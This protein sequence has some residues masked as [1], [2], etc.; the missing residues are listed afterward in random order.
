MQ[1]CVTA[2]RRRVTDYPE[3]AS[4]SPMATPDPLPHVDSPGTFRRW[5][6]W[7]APLL[8]LSLLAASCGDDASDDGAAAETTDLVS[9]DD[10]SSDDTTSD[11]S[12]ADESADA[13]TTSTSTTTTTTTVPPVPTPEASTIADLGALDRPIVIGHAGGD[14]SWPHSTMYAYREAALAGTDVL[15]MDVQL[16]A[17]GVL[18]VQHDYTTDGTTGVSAR[19]RDLTLEELQALDNGH[20]W[21]DAWRDQEQPL[22]SYI[23]RGIRLGEVPPPAGYGPDDFRVETFRSV[24]EAFPD[25]VLDVE[26][27]IPDGDDGESDFDFAVEGAAVLAA[28]IEELGRTDSVVVVSFNDDVMAAFHEMAPDVVTSPGTDALTAWFLEG[29]E[30]LPTDTILQI[31]P[32]SGE[33][34][35]LRLPGFLEK[36]AEEGRAVW[37]WPND[38][39]AQENPDFYEELLQ[40]D[41]AGVLVGHPDQ[42]IE[43]F[44][45]IGVIPA[46]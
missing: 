31:P 2:Q 38:A 44:I 43:R 17:D 23:Y 18:V 20:W 30:L 1:N 33:L 13:T 15:E 37:V 29:A 7:L 4:V 24:A 32:I 27:K 41:I 22:E 28:E 9:T 46:A 40:F 16:T 5:T 25:H 12:T 34:D 11:N 35:V 10:T 42:A 26:I 45:E 6:T 3:I 21:S 8:A 36:A 39:S 14:Q 19:V